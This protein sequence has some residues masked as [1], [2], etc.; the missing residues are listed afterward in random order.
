MHFGIR[1]QEILS[2]LWHKWGNRCTLSYDVG[3]LASKV[4]FSL[5]YGFIVALLNA[6]HI[7]IIS[8]VEHL[9]NTPTHE[10]MRWKGPDCIDLKW[11]FSP[12]H[13]GNCLY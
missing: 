10:Q 12:Q 3:K 2:L 5:H 8:L 4:N 13:T 7:F 6:I 11:T 9:A 1:L